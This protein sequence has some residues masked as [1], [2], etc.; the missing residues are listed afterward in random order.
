MQPLENEIVGSIF[1]G[2]DLLH[3]HVLLA[4]Q[5]LRIEGR[6]GQDV[7]QHVERERHVG[8]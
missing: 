7:R 3:D 5:L 8:L 4:P 2:A 1:H 6:F